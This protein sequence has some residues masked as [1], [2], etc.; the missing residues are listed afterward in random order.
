MI[1]KRWN[2]HVA[3]MLCLCAASAQAAKPTVADTGVLDSSDEYAARIVS[4]VQASWLGGKQLSGQECVDLPVSVSREG[5][6]KVTGEGSGDQAVC[7]S[8]RATISRL[9]KFPAPPGANFEKYNNLL[10]TFQPG[11]R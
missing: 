10:L 6:V 7:Q 8:A 11:S 4:L 3:V 9:R 2:G 5:V 1:M